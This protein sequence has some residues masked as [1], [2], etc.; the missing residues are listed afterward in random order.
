MT[1]IERFSEADIAR[2]VALWGPRDL[3]SLSDAVIASKVKPRLRQLVESA[4]LPGQLLLIGPTGCG[5]TLTAFAL[6]RR[7]L[8]SQYR[9]VY[10]APDMGDRIRRIPK[11]VWQ[12]V[13]RLSD[14]CQQHPLGRG[15]A[16]DITEAMDAPFLI[17]DEFGWE[18]AR[19]ATFRKV[20]AA[21]SIDGLPTIA[22]SG[23]T[24]PQIQ[25]RYG[26]AVVRRL[27]ELR[28][29]KTKTID[30]HPKPPKKPTA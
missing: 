16:D 8:T 20:I 7:W 5:K 3:R 28:G 9:R 11:P 29:E 15:E 26:D 13:T 4:D 23:F 19:D 1:E 6:A 17:L 2:R 10:S 14:A 21:R 30:L 25:E 18:P 27:N 24:K 22:T 12:N